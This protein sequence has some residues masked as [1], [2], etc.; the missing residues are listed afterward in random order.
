MFYDLDFAEQLSSY[1]PPP[2]FAHD[3]IIVVSLIE[4]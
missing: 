2:L 4:A 1:S 3:W